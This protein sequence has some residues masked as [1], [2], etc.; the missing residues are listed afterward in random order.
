MFVKF[1]AGPGREVTDKRIGWREHGLEMKWE[2]GEL[3]PLLTVIK[4]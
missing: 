3:R 4:T 2:L 1:H